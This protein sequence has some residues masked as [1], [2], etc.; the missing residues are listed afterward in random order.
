MRNPLVARDGGEEEIPMDDRVEREVWLEATAD[1]VWDAV[2]EGG[3]LAE[4]ARLELWPGG[5]AW[6][7]CPDGIREGWVEEASAPGDS[8]E[9]RLAFWWAVDGEPASRVELTIEEGAERTR[10]RV[11]EA[12]P[13]DS[14]DL[15]GLPL[16]RLGRRSFGPALAA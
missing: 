15:V 12:R 9:G 6:F 11:V 14:L 1:E 3:W 7:C 4:E 8:G 13:L 16:F 10:L 5:D 2:T